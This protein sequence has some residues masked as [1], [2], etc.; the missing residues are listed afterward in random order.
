MQI[1]FCLNQKLCIDFFFNFYLAI[2]NNTGSLIY[3]SAGPDPDALL[4][5]PYGLFE[6]G[7][8]IKDKEGALARINITT[9]MVNL[10]INV[11]ANFLY[12]DMLLVSQLIV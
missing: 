2:H 9:M 6:L 5:L 11:E 12:N 7:V 3:L 8:D 10:F 4:V 1:S